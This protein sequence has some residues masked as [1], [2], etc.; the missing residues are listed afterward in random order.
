MKIK[1]A[2]WL[3]ALLAPLLALSACG[4]DDT[5]D[6][7]AGQDAGA[8][9]ADGDVSVAVVAKGYASPFWA[10]VKAGSEAAGTDLGV[11]VT[12]NG[13]DTELE[14]DRQMNLLQTALDRSPSALVFAALDSNA[15]APYL[16]SAADRDIPVIAFD[17]GVESDIP[18]TTVA[19]DN[20]AAAAEAAAHMI[21]ELGG[22]GKV[23]V[24]AHSQTGTTGVLR[25]DG[26]VEHIEANAPDIEVVDIQ[27]N[28]SD[29]NKAQQQAAAILQAN[30]DLVGI[31][32]T[33]DD[34]AV[35]AANEVRT[36]GRVG[37]VTI[38]GFDSG[39]AQL[40]FIRDGVIR[41]S[42]TQN[43]YQIGYLAVVNA[44]DAVNGETLEPVVD[45]GY[46]WYDADNMDQE[47]I[48]A[49]LYD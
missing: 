44:L 33:D 8:P 1:R 15:A 23:A 35:A 18:L 36:A 2:S 38:I 7:G 5:G 11:A 48:A 29:Q 39:A 4:S 22:E 3:A 25:R 9:A 14:I 16:Q 13:P 41:G 12:F 19:T 32:A 27:Y 34:G 42:I 21:D 43:P 30:P 17:S 6:A 47:D 31:F 26:F 45:S 49:A 10:T 37:D 40:Q 46:F 20:E 24:L 28:D